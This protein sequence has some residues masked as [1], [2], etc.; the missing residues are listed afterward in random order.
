VRLFV[1]AVVACGAIASGAFAIASACSPPDSLDLGKCGNS[2]VEGDAGEQCDNFPT[3]GGFL[4]FGPDA[5]TRACKIACGDGGAC[6]SGFGCGVDGVCRNPSSPPKFTFASTTQTD[7]RELSLGDF[8]G[9]GRLDVVTRGIGATSVYF[10]D[11]SGNTSGIGGPIS[12]PRGR[13]TTGKLPNG[14]GAN[15]VAFDTTPVQLGDAIALIGT[16]LETWIGQSDRTLQPIL[17]SS[18]PIR[19]AQDAF[20]L[21]ASV[22]GKHGGT[23]DLLTVALTPGDPNDAGGIVALFQPDTD[24]SFFPEYGLAGT[25]NDAGVH[26]E[27]PTARVPPNLQCDTIAIGIA[28]GKTATVLPTCD[29]D[30][31]VPI[32]DATVAVKPNVTFASNIDLGPVL[33][34]DWDHDGLVDVITGT[35]VLG[36][37]GTLVGAIQVAFGNPDGTFKSGVVVTTPPVSPPVF[38]VGDIDGDNAL[39]WVDSAGVVLTRT[40][41]RLLSTL[42]TKQARIVDINRDGFTDAIALSTAGIDVWIGSG[43]L[44]NHRLYDLANASTF[45]IGDLDGDSNL[46]ILAGAN[47]G[48]SDTLYVLW[49]TQGGFP[50]APVAVGSVRE[51][52]HLATGRITWLFGD[53][54]DNVASAIAVGADETGTALSVIPIQG[55][56][57]RQLTSPFTVQSTLDGGLPGASALPLNGAIGLVQLDGGLV[58]GVTVLASPP[59]LDAG[60]LTLQTWTAPATSPS[61]TFDSTT[62][63]APAINGFSLLATSATN[64]QGLGMTTIDLDPSAN[65]GDELVAVLPASVGGQAGTL[66][67][68]RLETSGWMPLPPEQFDGYVRTYSAASALL[69]VRVTRADFDG[70]GISDLLLVYGTIKNDA[71]DEDHN[72]AEVRFG[73]GALHLVDA[74]MIDDVQ[75]AA[76]INALGDGRKQLMVARKDGLVLHS[77][78]TCGSGKMHCFDSGTTLLSADFSRTI[79]LVCGD[80]TGDGVD[81]VITADPANFRVYVANAAVP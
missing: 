41:T 34:G 4:C 3:E 16:G 56:T 14:G 72:V 32:T 40:G 65:N 35:N 60:S 62:L 2:I 20:V 51:A 81:D 30:G 29:A 10:F 19:T 59:T 68:A 36:D 54:P 12:L 13:V 1:R 80:V 69:P 63:I 17:F 77:L 44:M 8:D 52:R 7:V 27:I 42:A 47:Q 39:D 43:S 46:D 58:P 37:A 66:G 38:A 50:A 26:G 48:Q 18:L 71:G 28:R 67:F 6:P 75:S 55:H 53:P 64:A 31:A 70:D 49:G 11:G 5:G 73:D 25:A 21:G 45:A 24:G 9:D 33:F 61:Q 76:P 15:L 57:N 74:V 22:T 78:T 23:D 79:D